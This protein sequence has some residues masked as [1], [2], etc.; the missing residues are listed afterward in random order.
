MFLILLSFVDCITL[1]VLALQL[2][3]LHFSHSIP[4]LLLLTSRRSLPQPPLTPL[5]LTAFLSYLPTFPR[6]S[7]SRP[8]C[9][10]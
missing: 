1:L 6:F 9:L 3:R 4:T 5:I 7:L 10:H 8:N 2:L